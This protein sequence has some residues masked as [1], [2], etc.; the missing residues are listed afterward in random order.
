[1]LTNTQLHNNTSN[2]IIQTVTGIYPVTSL[3]I[4]FYY[5]CSV[6]LLICRKDGT[7]SQLFSQEPV[8]NIQNNQELKQINISGKFTNGMVEALN[9]NMLPSV[10]LCTP[11]YEFLNDF[12]NELTDLASELMERDLLKAYARLNRFRFPTIILASNGIIY[13]EVIYNLQA[14]LKKRKIPDEIIT[15]ICNKITRASVMQGAYREDNLYFPHNK[16]LLK[17]AIPKHELFSQVVEPLN[18]KG[19]LFSIHTNP[20]KIEFE[21]AMVNIATNAVAMVFALEKKDP[22]LNKI[23]LENALSPIDATHSRFVK[24]LQTA[25]FEIGKRAGAFAQ[26]E[27]FDRV[28]LPRKEQIL[29]HDSKHISSSLY[30]FRHMIK[31][32][33]F[34]DKLPPAEQAL[35]YPLKCFAR[36]YQ[37]SKELALFEEL[38]Q[39]IL[40]NITFARK[41]AKFITINF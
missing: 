36:H 6:D 24:E 16:G 8:L 13:D 17:I 32:K 14:N 29:K 34:P 35:I 18:D 30:A 40:N 27:T 10:I 28:W 7:T 3:G 39:M 2:N 9:K 19:F 33:V 41:H 20:H 11:C 15:N 31:T 21:K 4:S 22:K 1:M 12:I 38:E 37:L 5:Y 25:I 26:S 23:D